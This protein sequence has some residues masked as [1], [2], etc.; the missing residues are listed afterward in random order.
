MAADKI[1]QHD[2][3]FALG[4]Q[5]LDRHTADI[6]GS[7]GHQYLHRSPFSLQEHEFG[8]DPGIHV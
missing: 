1:I 7:A 8:V 4:P 3:L 2:N 6:T 5:T